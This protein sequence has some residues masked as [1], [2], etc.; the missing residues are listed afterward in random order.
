MS[1]L[2]I[3]GGAQLNGTITPSGNKNAILPMLCSTIMI[4]EPVKINNVPEIEDVKKIV[5]LIRS[6]GGSVSWSKKQK[7][8][9]ISNKNLSLESFEK[10]GIPI[11]MRA[12][13]LLFAPMMHR[14][15]KVVINNNVGGCAL[16]IRE[17]DP[18]VPMLRSMA[19]D[20][21]EDDGKIIFDATNGMRGTDLWPNYASVTGTENV[22]MA[23]VL[24]KGT[25][26]LMNA[27]AEPHVQDL[28]V[29][30]NSVGAKIEG[31]GSSKLVIEG[32]EKLT[33]GEGTVS[34]DHQEIATFLA[35][36]AMTHG[37]I[38]VTNAIP[39]HFPLIVHEFKKLGV[40]IEYEGDTAIVRKNQSFEP[41]K[42]FTT[43][44][45]PRIEAAPWPYFPADIL[46][47]M[48]ALSLKTNGPIRFWN[49]VYEAALFWISELVKMNAKIE[50]ADPHRIIVLGPTELKGATI[51][52]P[53]I[54]RAT[55]A[56]MMAAMAAN[57]TSKLKNIDSIYR[58]HPNFLGNLRMLG[59]EIQ[60]S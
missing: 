3:T 22:I 54:I 35:L 10:T 58:A 1:D 45:I 60:E 42:P 44:Y 16:G 31:I 59:A 33:G 28:C 39:H 40:N 2:L 9:S 41:E 7:T 25:T 43:N 48:V 56:L 46:P 49:K 57:G 11:D 24:A 53:P 32:V 4:D 12:S 50:M 26:T 20:I 13:I 18:H 21:Q 19:A 15:G 34:S 6:L 29:F 55:V 17:L 5:S 23:A 8:L 47:L 36:G 14:F 37:E 38:R 30:L 51:Q 27:A 52:C